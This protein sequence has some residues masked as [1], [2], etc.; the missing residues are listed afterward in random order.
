MLTLPF[1]NPTRL[2]H[3]YAQSDDKPTERTPMRALSPV[4]LATAVVTLRTPSGIEPGS[5]DLYSLLASRLHDWG[6][7]DFD[8]VRSWRRGWACAERLADI[9][10]PNQHPLSVWVGWDALRVLDATDALGIEVWLQPDAV[11]DLPR[12]VRLH[13]RLAVQ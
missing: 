9:M 1:S 7:Q 2:R 4:E 12:H 6:A 5:P 13:E 3:A 11:T 8:N 10:S